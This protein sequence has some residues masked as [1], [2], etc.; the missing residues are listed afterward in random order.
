MGYWA[1]HGNSTTDSLCLMVIQISECFALGIPCIFIPSLHGIKL[2]LY[3]LWLN[4]SW[5][6]KYQ[7]VLWEF[8]SHGKCFLLAVMFTT[9]CKQRT[10]SLC[11]VISHGIYINMLRW[12]VC[13]WKV[14]WDYMQ[15][16]NWKQAYW[17]FCWRWLTV[18][19]TQK[20]YWP[21][22]NRYL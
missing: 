1:S 13:E 22:T 15:Q 6:I 2:Y 21:T 8:S 4:F 19:K 9:I 17:H 18:N 20:W 7:T 10:E 16:A 11:F 14:L 5:E 3:L 12:C